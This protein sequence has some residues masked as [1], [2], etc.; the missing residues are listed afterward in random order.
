MTQSSY[1]LE[2]MRG[3]LL[4]L[5]DSLSKDFMNSVFNSLNDITSE[6]FMNLKENQ[7]SISAQFLRRVKLY[8]DLIVD[9]CRVLEIITHWVPEIFLSKDSIHASRLLNYFVFMLNTIFVMKT[10]KVII[11]YG[12]RLQTKSTTL[13]QFLAPFIGILVNLYKGVCRFG[14]TN[15]S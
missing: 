5:D 1:F 7:S 2:K 4:V 8:F 10:D 14:N 9:L 13:P 15:N 6:L 3:R 12:Q 11:E